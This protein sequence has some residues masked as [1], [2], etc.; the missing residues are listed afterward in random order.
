LILYLIFYFIAILLYKNDLHTLILI[1]VISHLVLLSYLFEVEFGNVDYYLSDGYQYINYPEDWIKELDRAAWGYLNYFE[2]YYD[3]FGVVFAKFINIPLILVFN[4]LLQNLFREKLLNFNIIF[5]LPYYFYLGISNLRDV[6]IMIVILVVMLTFNKK[7]LK[8][9]L[10]SS[11]SLLLLYVLRPFIAGI[12]F[13]VISYYLLKPYLKNNYISRIFYSSIA[14]MVIYIFYTIFQTKILQYSYNFKYY[15]GEGLQDRVVARKAEVLGEVNSYL[16]WVKAHLRYIFTPMPQSLFLSSFNNE[17]LNYGLTSRV[18]RI[19][20]QLIYYGYFVYISLNL[21]KLLQIYRTLSSPMKS[22]LL[23][24][25]SY[26]PIYSILHFGG[27]HQRTKLPF[28]VCIILIGCLIYRLNQT[29]KSE[30]TKN[31]NRH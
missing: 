17:P 14:I 12:T 7:E 30:K 19:I 26:L 24:C 10:I 18:L 1:S 5:L 25:F 16:F 9:K 31:S 22:F 6:L 20:N 3:I 23:I 29:K 13:L 27:V 4:K 21:P 2:K 8:Y 28:Q 15:I 11:I